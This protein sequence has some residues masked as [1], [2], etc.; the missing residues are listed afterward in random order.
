MKIHNPKFVDYNDQQYDHKENKDRRHLKCNP[1]ELLV[2]KMDI[3]QGT[4][5]H[6]SQSKEICMLSKEMVFGALLCNYGRVTFTTLKFE[7][8]R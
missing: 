6:I 4:K 7:N 1:C 5:I 3:L 8:I 2:Y